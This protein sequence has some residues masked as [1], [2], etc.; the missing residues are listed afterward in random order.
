MVEIEKN[1]PMPK[2]TNTGVPKYPFARMELGDSIFTEKT[3]SRLVRSAAYSF[4][5]YH[6]WR[7][8]S[9]KEGEGLRIWRI[10]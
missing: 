2:E 5:K 3:G 4:G 7:F 1:V 8:A 6:G 9:R 10:A